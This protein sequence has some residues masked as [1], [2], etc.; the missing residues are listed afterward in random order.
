MTP[1]QE[2]KKLTWRSVISLGESMEKSTTWT[3]TG[4]AAI[5]TLIIGNLESISKLISLMGIKITLACFILSLIFGVISKLYG[6]SLS[7]ALQIVK[8]IEK[9]LNSESGKNI[10][11]N[12]TIDNQQLANEIAEPFYWPLSKLMKNGMNSGDKDFLSG[13][14]KLVGI[15]SKQVFTNFSHIIFTALG[16]IT[17]VFFLK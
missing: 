5:V 2:L 9:S 3:L 13:D 8:E 7:A 1:E 16:L 14:K 4:V 11:D 6:M 10:I 12:I 15:Y 17:I